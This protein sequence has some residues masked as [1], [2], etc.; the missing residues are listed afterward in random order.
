MSSTLPTQTYHFGD[1]TL[2]G[3]LDQA[4]LAG[5]L[6]KAVVIRVARR[7]VILEENSDNQ[8]IYFVLTGRV[9]AS[10]ISED[11]KEISLADIGAGD[12]FGEFSVI[13][14][15]PTSAAVMATEDSRV[16]SISR[17]RFEELL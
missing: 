8:N 17:S 9:R 6:G 10:Y 1:A 11:G 2:L 16:A 7:K 3:Q 4:S 15:G 13:D 12:C 5:L 14:G